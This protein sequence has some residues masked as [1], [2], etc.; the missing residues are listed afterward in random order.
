MKVK[1]DTREQFHVI[2][3]DET[4]L[5]ANM[6]EE[7]E[8]CLLQMLDS[9]VKNVILNLGDI[10]TIEI[11]A[12][13]SLVKIQQQFYEKNASMVLFGLQSSVEQELD[14]LS[15]LEMMNVTPTESEAGDIVLME[16]IEREL[17]NEDEI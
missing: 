6:T 17:L 12:A 8:N 4:S 3:I 14:Q 13:E 16:E 7:M 10:Q 1:I 11:A 15:L 9:D 5:A 2:T